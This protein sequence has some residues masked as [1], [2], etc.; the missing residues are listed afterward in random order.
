MFTCL[1]SLCCALTLA[2]FDK[3]AKRILKTDD[4]TTGEYYTT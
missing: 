4:A 3:R 1:F 2:F